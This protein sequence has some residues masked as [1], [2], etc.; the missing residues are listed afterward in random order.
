MF[1]REA[2]W[3]HFLGIGGVFV[4]T[5][6]IFPEQFLKNVV[7][8]RRAFSKHRPF[9]C[10][11]PCQVLG[12]QSC[13]CRSQLDRSQRRVRRPVCTHALLLIRAKFNWA[14]PNVFNILMDFEREVLHTLAVR[15][16][17]ITG[18]AGPLFLS[19]RG[20]CEA[21]FAVQRYVFSLVDCHFF[22]PSWRKVLNSRSS[23]TASSTGFEGEL[24]ESNSG[25]QR[26]LF[27]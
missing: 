14:H 25:H 15:K 18:I 6:P 2:A 21:R 27:Q 1:L 5:K 20:C 11:G 8:R 19:T 13:L 12:V 26:R 23:W 22:L 4:V 24:S 10:K 17:H 7:Y 9:E 16:L 3:K